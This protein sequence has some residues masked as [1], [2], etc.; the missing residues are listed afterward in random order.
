MLPVWNWVPLVAAMVTGASTSQFE[1]PHSESGIL[2][3][4]ASLLKER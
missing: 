4:Q 3:L 2:S 1:L